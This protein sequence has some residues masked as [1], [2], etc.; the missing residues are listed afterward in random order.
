MEAFISEILQKNTF[1][2]YNVLCYLLV[3]T[4]KWHL[5]LS[6]TKISSRSNRFHCRIEN[7]KKNV[8][9]YTDILSNYIS[10]IF[11]RGSVCLF[12]VFLYL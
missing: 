1:Y 4:E 3:K 8:L 9:N 11:P 7:I 5:L 10:I 2:T 6:Y 12:N